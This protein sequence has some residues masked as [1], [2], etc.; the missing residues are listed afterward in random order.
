M[1]DINGNKK[2]F[3]RV[4]RWIKVRTNYNVSKRNRLYE[5]AM[6]ENGCK[7]NDANFNPD[8]GLFLDYFTFNGRNYAT[9]QFYLLDCM[10]I[11]EQ[12]TYTEN[13]EKHSL[14]AVD[15][16]GNLYNPVYVEFDAFCER[17]RVY[18]VATD[19]AH[20]HL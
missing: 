17:V 8:N 12:Y 11:G 13:K 18:E 14:S 10:W 4:S 7:P 16:F 9:E 3:Y 6:D 5:F 19:N 1:I 20:Y 15:M 2:D